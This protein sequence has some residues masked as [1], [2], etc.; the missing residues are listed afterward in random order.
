MKIIP[1]RHLLLM[2]IFSSTCVFAQPPGGGGGGGQG[3]QGGPPGQQQ[4]SDSQNKSE[5]ILA[6]EI[7]KEL[8]IT[9]EQKQKIQQFS[10]TNSKALKELKKN[11]QEERTKLAAGIFTQN[12]EITNK[13]EAELEKLYKE[14]LSFQKKEIHYLMSVLDPD[15]NEKAQDYFFDKLGY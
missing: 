4:S 11:E 1:F 15:Q 7:M 13:A 3:G 6:P 5:Q 14:K 2:M 8:D 9:T 10:K 12:E